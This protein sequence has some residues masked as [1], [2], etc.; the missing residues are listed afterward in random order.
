KKKKKKI[1]NI[2]VLQAKYGLIVC[3]FLYPQR[4]D[5]KVSAAVVKKSGAP[6]SGCA[7]LYGFVASK[8]IT[9]GEAPAT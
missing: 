1:V 9:S 8:R 3:K 6:R 2:K 4:H 5:G 7:A